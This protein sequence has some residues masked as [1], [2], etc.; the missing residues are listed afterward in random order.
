MTITLILDDM[1][2]WTLSQL[3]DKLFPKATVNNKPSDKAQFDLLNR[4]LTEIQKQKK[5]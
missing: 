3:R 5:P 2:E 1:D 4:I